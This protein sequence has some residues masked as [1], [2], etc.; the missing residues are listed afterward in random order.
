MTVV[1]S[2]GWIAWL[3]GDT[4]AEAYAPF[5]HGA[6]QAVIVPTIVLFEVVR[7]VARER[8]DTA[9]LEIAGLLGRH[10]VVALEAH[11]AVLAVRLSREH[12]LATADALVYAHAQALGVELATSDAAFAGLAGVRF[13]A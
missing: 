12:R 9:A 11:V 13:I 10:R 7:W 3:T 8:G 2:C 1:D 6:A 4:R 5:L